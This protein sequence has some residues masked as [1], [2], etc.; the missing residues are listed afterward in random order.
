[1]IDV[2]Q[3]IHRLKQGELLKETE[4]KIL[5]QKAKEILQVEENVI[6]VEAP[7]TVINMI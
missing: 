1:M 2:D 7:V 5:C 6:Q 4:V 3:W